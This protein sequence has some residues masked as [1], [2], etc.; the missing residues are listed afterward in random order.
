[1]LIALFNW[2]FVR[3]RSCLV[4]LLNVK[5]TVRAR[6]LVFGCLIQYEIGR[7]LAPARICLLFSMRDRPFARARS[8]S[9]A[10]II[11]TLAV[12]TRPLVFALFITCRIRRSHAP[13]RVRL[14]FKSF[15]TLAESGARS[16]RWRKGAGLQVLL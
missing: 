14:L 9:V 16:A 4:V 5:L 8:H 2:Q 11:L 15:Q 12:R 13:A 3:A 6:P 1:L 7:M 10:A